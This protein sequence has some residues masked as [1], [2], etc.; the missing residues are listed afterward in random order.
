[1]EW[2][3][4]RVGGD[5]VTATREYQNAASISSGSQRAP[6]V[7]EQTDDGRP[8][9]AYSRV[10]AGRPHDAMVRRAR[11]ALHQ[12]GQC[13]MR[14]HRVVRGFSV[15][16]ADLQRGRILVADGA[17]QLRNRVR[18]H[19]SI[20]FGTLKY[21]APD[22]GAFASAAF[23]NAPGIVYMESPDVGHTTEKSSV[24]AKVSETFDMLRAE[25]LPRGPSRDLIRKVAEERWT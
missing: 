7:S 4:A 13:T 12:H 18:G 6:V 15:D 14:V 9:V 16:R 23:E 25:A 19:R 11:V 3:R 8:S 20:T 24:V 2:F 21:P 17:A 10:T 22:A 5:A 1:M